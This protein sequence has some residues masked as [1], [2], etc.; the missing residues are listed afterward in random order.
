MF[1]RALKALGFIISF[2]HCNVLIATAIEVGGVHGHIKEDHLK[3][4][5][6]TKPGKC[7]KLW[8]K[9]KLVGRC[10]GLV[11]YKDFHGGL[12]SSISISS[13]EDCRALCCNLGE[14]CISWQYFYNPHDSAVK[15]CKLTDKIIRLGLEATGTPDWC[16]PNPPAKWNGNRLKARGADQCEWGDEL[17]TQCFGLGDERKSAEGGK[18][19]TEQCAQACCKDPHCEMWQEIPGRGCFYNSGRGI[20]C[21]KDPGLYAGGRKCVKG[22]CDGREDE[23]LHTS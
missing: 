18:L 4:S 15:E 8:R 5:E 20:W 21:D 6:L 3:Q 2:S 22:F 1:Q 9:D 13:A 11:P 7:Q 23:V 10:F 16:D 17:P 19:T 12:V 14:K